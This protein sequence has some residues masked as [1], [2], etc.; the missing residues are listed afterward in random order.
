MLSEK[1]DFKMNDIQFQLKS[2]D[3]IIGNFYSTMKVIYLRLNPK[4]RANKLNSHEIH[5][6]TGKNIIN[7]ISDKKIVE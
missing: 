3:K 6:S 5:I 7:R 4:E 1:V 2:Y